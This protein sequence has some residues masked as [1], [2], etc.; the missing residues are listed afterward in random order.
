MCAL[1]MLCDEPGDGAV[2]PAVRGGVAIAAAR[3]G[4][5]GGG[6]VMTAAMTNQNEVRND[7]DL[8]GASVLRSLG[9]EFKERFST[10]PIRTFL[11][12]LITFGI[13]PYFGLSRRFRDYVSFE[14]QQMVHLAD[15]LRKHDDSRETEQLQDL[16]RRLRFR[17][18]LHLFGLL[19]VLFTVGLLVLGAQPVTPRRLIDLTYG[20][21]Q[22]STPRGI[23]VYLW[24]NIA[25]GLAYLVHFVQVS[26]HIEAF[27]RCVDQFNAVTRRLGVAE[28]KTPAHWSGFGIGWVLSAFVLVWL[29]A[30]WAIPMVMA[31][32]MQRRYVTRSALETR[33]QLAERMRVLLVKRRENPAEQVGREGPDYRV[34]LSRCSRPLCQA[35]VPADATFCPRCGAPAGPGVHSA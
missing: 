2:L 20:P 15:W 26:W 17:E 7:H 8:L 33:R 12:G 13:L 19:A 31:G 23:K 11:G 4:A 5:K 9:R 25:L 24:W 3:H 28:V 34:H 16:T 30:F 10:G 1:R 29:G 14:R 32:A 18:S 6:L 21:W 35:P 27:R 22:N